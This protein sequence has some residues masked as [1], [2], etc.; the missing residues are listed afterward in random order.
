V[1]F[2]VGLSGNR[3][4]FCQMNTLRESLCQKNSVE[5]LSRTFSPWKGTNGLRSQFIPHVAKVIRRVEVAAGDEHERFWF[6]KLTALVHEITPTE[7]AATL[8][9]AEM[10]DMASCVL[11]IINGFGHVWRVKEE[12]ELQQYVSG[13][14]AYLEALL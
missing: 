10:A 12:R 6:V 3:F 9:R 13:H 2:G 7:L 5:L 1:S 8:Q 4:T 14:R 11:A